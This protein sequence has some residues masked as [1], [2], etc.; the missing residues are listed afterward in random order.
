V[1]APA[2]VRV[3]AW[4][5]AQPGRAGQAGAPAV[6][7]PAPVL[8]WAWAEAQQER[9]WQAGTRP[10]GTRP[11][12]K[13]VPVQ[14]EVPAPTVETICSRRHSA[15]LTRDLLGAAGEQEDF[16]SIFAR[17]AQGLQMGCDS[18]G[19]EKIRRKPSW[20]PAAPRRSRGTGLGRRGSGCE[21]VDAGP[22]YRQPVE[23]GRRWSWA[24]QRRTVN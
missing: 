5:D 16:R 22:A 14:A 6:L 17:A 13:P 24:R 21:S 20:S 4:A 12:R 7:F 19:P 11:V 18:A 3:S 8:V 10:A 15:L 9:A 2:P 23:G 1:R